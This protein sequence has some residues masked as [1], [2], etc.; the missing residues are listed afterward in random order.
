MAQPHRIQVKLYFRDGE[1]VSPSAFVKVFHRWIQRGAVEDMLIDVHNYAHIHE[2]TGILLVGHEGDYAIDFADGRPG[3]LYRLKRGEKGEFVDALQVALRRVVAAAE[4]LEQDSTLKGKLAVARGE[5]DVAVL[6]RLQFPNE[7]DT[8]RA[9]EADLSRA[10]ES[11]VGMKDFALQRNE[12]DPRE[13][14]SIR[15]VSG[16]LIH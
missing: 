9:I 5:V 10:L 16:A 15:A 13:P 7:P 14:L 8:F 1:S 12:N 2:G 4:L 11:E 6:D 3:I